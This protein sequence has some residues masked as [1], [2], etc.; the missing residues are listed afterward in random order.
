MDQVREGILE[1]DDEGS[2]I[3]NDIT[4][5]MIDVPDIHSFRKVST[6]DFFNSLANI[7]NLDIFLNK[8]VKSTIDFKWPIVRKYTILFLFIPFIVQL[9]TF[10]SYSNVFQGQY[11]FKQSQDGINGNLSVIIILYVLAIYFLTMELLQISKQG[12]SYFFVIWNL[13]DICVPTLILI[14]ISYRVH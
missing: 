1:N 11:D 12:L 6:R 2:M 8:V 9:A 7:D 3:K 14:V 10:I 4:T 5:K 13:Q